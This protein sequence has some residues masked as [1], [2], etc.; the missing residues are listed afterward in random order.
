MKALSAVGVKD[1][2]LVD[3]TGT[4]EKGLA[5]VPPDVLKPKATRESRSNS[6]Y[7]W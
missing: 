2:V 4:S 6:A 1:G 5:E 3:L 7:Q